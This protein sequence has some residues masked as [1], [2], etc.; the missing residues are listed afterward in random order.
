MKLGPDDPATIDTRNNLA[1]AYSVAGRV[2]D[3]IVLHEG[4]L[5]LIE[6]KLGKDHPRTLIILANLATN[7][8]RA[9]RWAEAEVR[10]RDAL[11]RRRKSVQPDSPLLAGDLDGIGLVLLHQKKWLEA[12]GVLRESLAICEKSDPNDWRRFAAMSMLGRALVGQ[13]RFA[14]AERLIVTGYESLKAHE[15]T[16]PQP[17]RSGVAVAGRSIVELYESWGKT[18][19]AARWRATQAKAPAKA[20]HQP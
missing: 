19:Q 16:I 20:E 10:R 13:R 6:P 3:A 8:E 9:D 2:A 17:N 14:E 4:T 1:A 12:E 5:K 18:D 11:A 15:A 7:L